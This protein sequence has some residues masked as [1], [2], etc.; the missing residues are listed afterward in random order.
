MTEKTCPVC[1]APMKGQGTGLR[2]PDDPPNK[3]HLIVWFCTADRTHKPVRSY[4]E[5]P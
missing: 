2:M 5:A 3:P 4:E 1:G